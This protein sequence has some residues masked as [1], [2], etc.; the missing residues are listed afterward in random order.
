MFNSLYKCLIQIIVS[1]DVWLLF[2]S[3]SQLFGVMSLWPMLHKFSVNFLT[4]NR[5]NIHYIRKFQ[6]NLSVN[7]RGVS[8]FELVRHSKFLIL[9]ATIYQF[10]QHSGSL[11]CS[12]C[13]L[14]SLFSILVSFLFSI[15]VTF[16]IESK[17]W[18][19]YKIYLIIQLIMGGFRMPL[20]SDYL[21]NGH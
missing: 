16:I 15:L 13:W 2:H 7:H 11:L 1:E 9:P 14:P 5:T 3:W 17:W 18:K 6:L 12:T 20:L 8:S 19:L 10:V 21:S 4:N